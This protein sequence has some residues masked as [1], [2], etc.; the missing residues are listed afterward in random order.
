MKNYEL[1]YTSEAPYGNEDLVFYA[2]KTGVMDDGWEKWSLPLGNGYMGVNVF[3]RTNSER[4]QITENSFSNPFVIDE[5]HPGGNG[6]LMNFCD[7]YLDFGHTDAQNYHRSLS[8]CDA[9]ARTTYDFDGITY[10]REHFTSYP[11]NVFV[12]RLRAS[13]EGAL[14]FTVRPEIPFVAPYLINEDDGMGRIGEVRTE[15]NVIVFG[16]ELE[17]YAIKYEGQIAVFCDGG[18]LISHG[19]TIEVKNANSAVLLLAVGTNYKM[20]SRVFMECEPRQKLAPYDHPHERVSGI[21]LCAKR[22]S[23][24]ELFKRHKEDYLALIS[25]AEVDIGGIC[26]D[27]PTDA[28]IESYR[29]GENQR[30]LEELYF[31]YGRYLLISSSRPETYPA[32][33]QGTWSKYAS[34]PWSSGYWHN[35]NIQMNY[36]LAFNTGLHELF[37]PYI[38]YFKAYKSLARENADQYI[39]RNFPENYTENGT[40]GIAVGT[41]GWLYRISGVPNP[42]EGSHSGP[43]TGAFTAKL[44]TDYYE[45][46]QD[47][48]N[49]VEAVYSANKE[50]AVFLSKTLEQQKDGT[51]LVKYS[52]SPEQVHNGKYYH[53]K[54]CAFD[55]QMVYECYKDTLA[56]AD[57]L[58]ITDEFIEKIR[59]DINKLE[60]VQ[61]GASGQ[62]KEYR[63]EVCYGDIGEYHHRHISHLVGLYPGTIINRNNPAWLSAAEY[64]LNERG[65]ISTGWSTA[66]KLN[67]WA[68]TKNGKR[69]YDLLHRLLSRC[70]LPNLW[71]SHPPFQIDGNFGGTAGIAEMLLQSHEGYLHLLPALPDCWRDGSFK[72]LCARGGFTLCAEWHDGKV[73]HVSVLAKAGGTLKMLV[74]EQ[75]IEKELAAGEKS[76]WEFL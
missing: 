42:G 14:S 67:A 25:R 73:V 8:L 32:N 60:P 15:D 5:S 23:Y 17:Y 45:Y 39:S 64:S 30:Y 3:G 52:E 43:G 33:L 49:L 47:T 72:G 53:T 51:L 4:L 75:Y 66:H 16:G 59:T 29:N 62:I 48:K 10:T 68:R 41:G 13:T 55:Q 40:N 1:W 63:E 74:G 58:G 38:E 20:E 2:H 44:F 9:V 57:A 26:P 56:L 76:I 21:L 65:D 70:T 12:T 31:T 34:S 36:W 50:T 27:I 69:A 71:D 18:E 7:L 24:E 46:S 6:G 22:Y 37:L 19:K 28:L 35:I 54:G 61:V 11:D